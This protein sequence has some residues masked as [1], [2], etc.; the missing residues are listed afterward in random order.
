LDCR[1]LFKAIGVYAAKQV[2]FEIHCIKTGGGLLPVGGDFDIICKV[3]KLWKKFVFK[4]KRVR[5]GKQGGEHEQKI[6]I[7]YSFGAI[8]NRNATGTHQHCLSRV[9]VA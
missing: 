5:G 1:R 7:V 9:L 4:W 6:H 2:L 8:V 3:I